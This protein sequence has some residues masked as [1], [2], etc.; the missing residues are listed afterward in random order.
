M[1]VFYNV[2]QKVCDISLRAA[3]LAHSHA[4][5]YIILAFVPIASQPD[6]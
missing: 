6:C 4:A 5:Y 3:V 2:L 1:I